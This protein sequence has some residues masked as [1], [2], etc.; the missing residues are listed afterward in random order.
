MLACVLHRQLTLAART[1]I[2]PVHVSPPSD[3]HISPSDPDGTPEHMVV[4]PSQP[5]IL[6]ELQILPR[7]SSGSAQYEAVH[8][9]QPSMSGIS[10]HSL[11]T[12]ADASADGIKFWT[13]ACRVSMHWLTAVLSRSPHKR[14]NETQ[15]CWRDSFFLAQAE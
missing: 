1:C 10:A 14:L 9:E 8:E 13:P 12:A 5:S 15:S 7:D 3:P 6:I 11:A 2:T 4:H